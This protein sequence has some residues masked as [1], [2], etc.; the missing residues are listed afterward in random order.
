MS[1]SKQAVFI[2]YASDDSGAALGICE[3]L[4]AVNIEVWF[5][6]T[7][8]RG[9]DAWD[10][11]IRGQIKTCALFLVVVS[12]NASAREEGYFRL[13]WKL[14][15]DRSH[16]MSQARTFILPVAIDRTPESSGSLPDR[17]REVQW[18]RL[19]QGEATP[20]FIDRV[21][22]LLSRIAATE[23]AAPEQ[24]SPARM[25]DARRRTTRR[26]MVGVAAILLMVV[27]AA[28]LKHLMSPVQ[29]TARSASSAS[30]SDVPM[31]AFKPPVHSVAVM[32]FA[33]LSGDVSQEYFSDGLSDEILDS[34]SRLAGLQVAARSSSFSFKGSPGTV[35]EIARKL[36][37]GA[38]LEGSVRRA[39]NKV[40]ISAQLVDAV[41]GFELWS[42]TYDRELKDILGLQTEIAK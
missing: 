20:A 1:E 41:T 7:E 21:K 10:A 37:V 6:Q 11:R 26:T 14:A 27:A 33:N 40:R 4:R 23:V 25:S 22:Q 32:P 34:F 38:L 16:L 42:Q 36:N 9:G 18:L 15:I 35:A 19:P 5:D 12:Q 13:E 31:P 3:A 24:A 30:S 39:G 29:Q 28:A 17:F 8:L 2:S